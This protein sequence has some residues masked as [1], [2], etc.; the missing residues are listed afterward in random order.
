MTVGY[1]VAVIHYSVYAVL[2]KDPSMM[3]LTN[4]KYMFAYYYTFLV[5]D[6]FYFVPMMIVNFK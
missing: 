4:Y 3:L 6:L 2:F 1:L 5:S